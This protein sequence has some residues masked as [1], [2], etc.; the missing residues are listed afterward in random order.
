LGAMD[1]DAFIAE[2]TKVAADRAEGY[3]FGDPD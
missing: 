2:A 1:V 3:G